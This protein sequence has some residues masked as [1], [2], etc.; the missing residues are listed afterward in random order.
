LSRNYNRLW[1]FGDSYSTPNVCVDPP[2]SFW[3]LAAK[4]LDVSTVINCSRPKLS[5][6]SVSQILVGEQQQ[7]D[8]DRD[9]FIIGLPTLERITVFD[10]FKDT[11]LLSN[12][13]DTKTW[14][15]EKQKITSHHGLVNL[16]YQE[17]NKIAVILSDRSWV[18]TQILR[19]I[20]LLTKWLDSCQASYAVVNLSKDLD[21][22]N[23]WGPSQFILNYCIQHPRCEIFKNS[24]HNCNLGL[25]KPGDYNQYGWYGHHDI[26]GNRHFFET[27]VKNKLC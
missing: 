4:H 21:I 11:P 5:F 18:E 12:V 19:Q 22:N 16:Q 13:F 14:H 23:Q 10:D 24:M 7:Y 6:D 15:A 8:W 17:L 3:G 9:F 25:H 27:T 2:D 1:V 26:N 20:F